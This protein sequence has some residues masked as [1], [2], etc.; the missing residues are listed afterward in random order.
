MKILFISPD[1]SKESDK[2][3]F[4]K[5]LDAVRGYKNIEAMGGH[6]LLELDNSALSREMVIGLVT[7]FDRWKIHKSPL[8]ALA[9]MLEDKS[10]H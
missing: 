4:F 5:G 10:G 3:E 1:L 9:Q 8:E 6:F 2:A 7:L